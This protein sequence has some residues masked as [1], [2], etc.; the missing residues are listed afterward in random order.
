MKYGELP[1]SRLDKDKER[2]SR[3]REGN[4]AV[5][6]EMETVMVNGCE[7]K[8]GQLSRPTSNEEYEPL[9]PIPGVMVHS[10]R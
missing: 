4:G 10:H 3:E 2:A 6:M 5:G 1:L 8:Q 7:V 9:L